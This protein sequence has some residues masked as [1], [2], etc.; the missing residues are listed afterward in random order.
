MGTETTYS[1]H[2]YR[3]SNAKGDYQITSRG[4]RVLQWL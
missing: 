3:V 1:A 2:Q 4:E